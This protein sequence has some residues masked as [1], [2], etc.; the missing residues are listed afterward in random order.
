MKAIKNIL[1]LLLIPFGTNILAQSP[2][3]SA[4]S[5][6]ALEFDG[7]PLNS[8]GDIVNIAPAIT[9]DTL[10]NVFTL[11]VWFNVKQLL[12]SW[13]RIVSKYRH[14]ASAGAKNGDGWGLHIVHS[15]FANAGALF[16][17]AGQQTVNIVL[18][19]QISVL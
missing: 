9:F 10:K 2:V 4:G 15:S 13:Q 11:E 3:N 6:G 7:V 16:F 8:S 12:P 17:S 18:L 14:E 19:E 1:T 5:G